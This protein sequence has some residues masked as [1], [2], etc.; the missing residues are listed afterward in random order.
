MSDATLSTAGT[1]GLA[2]PQADIQQERLAALLQLPRRVLLLLIGFGLALALGVALRTLAIP[3]APPGH[4]WSVSL[5]TGQP[6]RELVVRALHSSLTLLGAALAVALLLALLWTS[7]AL[8]VQ[9]LEER[10]GPLGSILKGLGRLCVLGPA[11][12]PVLGTGVLLLF[13]L[14]VQLRLLPV[15]GMAQPGG[16]DS[17][18]PHLVLPALA[19][20]L[21]PAALTA[22]AVVRELTWARRARPR[23]LWLAALCQ[24]LGILLGQV[25]GLLSTLVL[26]E[27]IFAWPGIGRLAVSSV[28]AR[29]YAALFGTLA[30]CAA[31]VLVGR[32]LAELCRWLARRLRLPLAGAEPA[33]APR[34]RRARIVWLVLALALVALPVGLALCGLLVDPEAALQSDLKARL[35][36]PSPA[37]LL[38]TDELGRDP[39]LRLQRAVPSTLGPAALAAALAFIPGLLSGALAAYLDRRRQWWAESLAD[40]LLLPADVLLFFPA[41]PGAMLFVGLMATSR[42]PGPGAT[43]AAIAAGLLLLPRCARAARDL[44]SPSGPGRG[45]RLAAGAALAFGALFAGLGLVVGLE[46]LGLGTLPPT[47]SLGGELAQAL[48]FARQSGAWLLA[49]AAAIS[50][51]ALALYAA[52]DALLGFWPSREALARLHE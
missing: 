51:C 11:A 32:L 52:A 3:G 34:P 5:H 36:P 47:P 26:V 33:A 43:A 8:L 44:W 40:L 14:A 1:D 7:V 10:L 38:G 19:L 9:R 13:I 18:L 28:M 16:A 24:G 15:A 50:T 20:A 25:G 37:H 48:R 49:V 39:A 21:L 30:A 6:V 46:Y 42:G 4:D 35:L 27:A 12:A 29:D 31:L 45:A 41:L 22:Q 17:R 2:R 23:R